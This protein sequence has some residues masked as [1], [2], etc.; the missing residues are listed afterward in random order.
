MLTRIP[1]IG[2][3][4]EFNP[5]IGA[6]RSGLVDCWVYATVV[7]VIGR[8]GTASLIVRVSAEDDEKIVLPLFRRGWT[9]KNDV[10]WG[11]DPDGWP[12]VCF[13]EI[14]DGNP[15]EEL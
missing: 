1:K 11:S 7:N 8:K 10:Q 15:E 3:V 6:Q 2:E 9:R 12:L 13:R 4:L 5:A 14:I